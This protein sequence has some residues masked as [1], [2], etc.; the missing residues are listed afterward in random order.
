M[1]PLKSSDLVNEF[2]FRVTVF[3]YYDDKKSVI[4]N[5]SAFVVALALLR[6]L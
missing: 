4:P 5:S 2:E 3:F 6:N 1:Q